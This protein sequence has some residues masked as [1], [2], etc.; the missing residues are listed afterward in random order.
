MNINVGKYG[1]FFTA[2]VG[3]GLTVASSKYSGTAWLPYAVAAASALGVYGVPNAPNMLTVTGTSENTVELA[4][5][6]PKTQAT[7]VQ[8]TTPSQ[9]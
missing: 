6:L 4:A 1:K 8:P 9:P 7:A 3:L 5:H 2:I